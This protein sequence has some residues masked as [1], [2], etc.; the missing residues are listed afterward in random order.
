MK[1]SHSLK[2]WGYRLRKLKG[3][4]GGDIEQWEV[5]TRDGYL[6]PTGQ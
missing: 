6:L 1:G 4:F 3:D 2:A 5:L